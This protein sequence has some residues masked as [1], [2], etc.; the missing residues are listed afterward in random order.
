MQP[1]K[2]T[3]YKDPAPS[4]ASYRMQRVW[5]TPVYRSL[6][7]TGLPIVLIFGIVLFYAKD[8]VVVQRLSDSVS[9]LRSQIENRPEF[10]VKLMRLQ[11]A[12]AGLATQVREAAAV[13]FPIS[14]FRLDLDALK[15]RIEQI[16]A[17]RQAALYM[18]AGGLLDVEITERMAAVIWRTSGGLELLDA[19]GVRAGVLATRSARADL[20]LIAGA[21]AND[22]VREALEI[23]EAA[24]PVA[25]RLRGLLRVGERRWDLV[26][27]RNQI[28]QLPE[29]DPVAA[30]E[31]VIA[32]QSAAD[33]LARDVLVVDMRDGRRPVLRL[34]APA[35]NELLRLR[36]IAKEEDA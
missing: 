4:R 31:R 17:V 33:V 15:T 12:S 30:L 24:S 6:I 23:L 2:E 34:S 27:D 16:D 35:R 21:G 29:V 25:D 10:T 3:P 7:R 13:E 20:P 18:R 9:N 28:I 5:L 19:N 36:A 8:P 11:G 14:S 26:L 32:L 1:I 22:R